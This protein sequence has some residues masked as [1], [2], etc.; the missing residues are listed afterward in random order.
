MKA[1]WLLVG[2]IVIAMAGCIKTEPVSSVPEITFKSLTLFEKYDSSLDTKIFTAE[3]IFS[4]IDGDADIAIPYSPALDTILP[5][6]AR[7]NI[8]LYPFEKVDNYYVPIIPDTSLHLPPPFYRITNNDK[9]TRTGQNKTLKGE[10][11][12]DMVDLP[13]GYDTIRYE[14]YMKDAAGHK[15]NVE[16]TS[17]L[18]F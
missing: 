9:F 18:G 4:F 5:D 7:F 2:L 12:I 17:D 15:S 1:S 10:I 8:F 13:I 6:S 3:L 11:T 14:F 16:V